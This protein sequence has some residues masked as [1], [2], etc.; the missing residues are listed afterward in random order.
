MSEDN[1]GLRLK[2]VREEH[3]IS[4]EDAYS[5]TKIHPK[6]LKAIEENRLSDIP[7][8]LYIKGF[9][10][11]YA[12]FLGVDSVKVLEDFS[13]MCPEQLKPEYP[14]QS[15]KE[16]V[17]LAKNYFS[18]TLFYVIGIVVVFLIAFI[19]PNKL[20]KSHNAQ[21]VK[22]KSVVSA[23]PQSVSP[24]KKSEVLSLTMRSRADVWIQVKADGKLI[25]KNIFKKGSI[26]NIEAFERVDLWVGNADVLILEL[27]NQRLKIPAKG[28]VKGIV[29]TA[30]GIRIEKTKNRK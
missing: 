26:K 18:I 7:S 14:L 1:V 25:Y 6:I 27:N 5:T 22:N 9:L 24:L 28:V 21:T 12:D 13:R 20:F 23:T 30:S 29:I 2:K 17:G 16:A 19:V 10:R 4:L 8:S 11:T 3:G 15:E